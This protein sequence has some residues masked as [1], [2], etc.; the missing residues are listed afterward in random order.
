MFSALRS[1]SVLSL[2]AVATLGC[3]GAP[4]DQPDLATVS[5]TVTKGGQPLANAIVTFTPEKGRQSTGQT[6][7]NGYYSLM[8]T[9]EVDGAVPG[10]HSVLVTLNDGEE[11]YE[12]GNTG[13]TEESNSVQAD[14]LEVTVKAGSNTIDIP[15]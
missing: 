4:S 11:D 12:D 15:L 3:G 8:Y 5:G 6:D 14:P 7:S 1:L 13:E 9:I 2:L 10:K